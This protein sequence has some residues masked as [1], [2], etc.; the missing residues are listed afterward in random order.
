MALPDWGRCGNRPYQAGW[1]GNQRFV[2]RSIHPPNM[3]KGPPRDP[4][5]VQQSR[6][7]ARRSE[8]GSAQHGGP[9]L[10]SKIAFENRFRS[11]KVP[12]HRYNLET[13]QTGTPCRSPT[14]ARMQNPSPPNRI[15]PAWQSL[16]V[17]PMIGRRPEAVA[18]EKAAANVRRFRGEN[19][20]GGCSP[21]PAPA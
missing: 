8:G 12:R 11:R 2:L 15:P 16:H 17:E 10:A 20:D 5:Y 6:I 9:C 1:V 14:L 3:R 19:S 18:P 7:G 13:E 4:G 21:P